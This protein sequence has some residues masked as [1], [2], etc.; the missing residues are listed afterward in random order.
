MEDK[1]ILRSSTLSFITCSTP[2]VLGQW[3]LSLCWTL[4]LPTLALSVYHASTSKGSV[5]K[6]QIQCLNVH[7]NIR[8]ETRLS[9]DCFSFRAPYGDG[10][11][12]SVSKLVRENESFFKI[13]SQP[14]NPAP[15]NDGL[16]PT[17]VG[18][19]KPISTSNL[20]ILFVLLFM[21][22]FK[23]WVVGFIPGVP[24]VMYT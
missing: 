24:T 21:R 11:Q 6:T 8:F 3:G 2:P 17:T 5:L 14:L 20:G 9:N 13:P 19:I 4:T 1:C 16:S 22:F 18:K 15:N 23:Y 10:K 12:Y 7:W